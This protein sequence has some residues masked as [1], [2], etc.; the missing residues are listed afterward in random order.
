MNNGKSYG[1][2]KV[3][4]LFIITP[5]H[6]RVTWESLLFTFIKN[7]SVYSQLRQLGRNQGRL[8]IEEQLCHFCLV[9]DI[10][11]F[12]KPVKRS[13]LKVHNKNGMH[14]LAKGFIAH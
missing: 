11:D 10:Y 13:G 5:Q 1:L 8:L 3:P 9:C 4:T 2:D 6:Q 14:V 12:I 7:S